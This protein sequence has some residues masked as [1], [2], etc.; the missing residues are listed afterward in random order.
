M[1]RE[2][3]KEG[4][5]KRRRWSVWGGVGVAGWLL[6]LLGTAGEA[7][8]P[9]DS[10]FGWPKGGVFWGTVLVNPGFV[11]RYAEWFGTPE[12]VAYRADLPARFRL[13]RRPERF[14]ADERTW[15]CRLRMW[16]VTHESY[17]ES[18]FDR[19][20]MAPNFLI[21]T[22]YGPE[23]QR[24]TFLLSNV[25][26]QRPEHNRGIWERLERVE[27]NRFAVGTTRFWTIVGPVFG[28]QV[29]RIGEARVGVPEGFFRVMV[30][31]LP[32]GERQA[33]AFLIPQSAPADGDLRHYVQ[34]VRAVEERVGLNFFPELPEEEQERLEREPADP[35]KWGL[36][37][38]W[39]NQPPSF[40]GG[41][42]ASGRERGDR[43]SREGREIR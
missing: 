10:P 22:R 3:E 6:V 14:E 23:A 30:R 40:W 9:E 4:G 15:R 18:G 39:A 7:S 2:E 12:W 43:R 25:A 28:E 32:N 42:S 8:L 16:C 13:E 27:V 33:I 5:G 21:G 36:D 38:A 31:E 26:P 41:E 17:R 34:P 35:A 20:H 1:R 11:V 24:A 19:G 37:E 29:P